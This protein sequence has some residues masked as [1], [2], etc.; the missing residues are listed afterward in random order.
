MFFFAKNGVLFSFSAFQ[1]LFS[2]EKYAKITSKLRPFWPNSFFCE[3][4]VKNWLNDRIEIFK[5]Y[6][7]VT[8]GLILELL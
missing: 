4:Y 2:F 3:D 7:T 8:K 1:K 6:M 5:P